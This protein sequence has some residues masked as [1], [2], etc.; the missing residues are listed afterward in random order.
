MK[1]R[2]VCLLFDWDGCLADTLDIWMQLYKLSLRQRGIQAD[3]QA[4]VRELFNDWSGPARFGVQDLD[5][6]TSEIKD[7]L[8]KRISMVSLNPGVL[9][10]LQELR[11]DGRRTAILTGSRRGFVEPVLCREGIQSLVELLICLDDVAQLKP[12]PEAVEKALAAF[13]VLPRQAVMV[14]DSSKDIEM[15]KNA[16]IATVLYLPDKNR[17]FYDQR[18]LL[19]FRP[20]F[21]IK[22][23]SE[24]AGIAG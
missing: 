2:Y 7:G 20:D 19:G 13:G 18:R 3:E 1:K 24:L 22:D 14:G 11:R 12:H 4:I 10:V 5:A 8:E 21:V 15:G 6:F 9:A 17:R 23:F 16:G